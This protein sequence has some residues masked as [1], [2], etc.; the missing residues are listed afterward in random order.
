VVTAV[1]VVADEVADLRFKVSRQ[2]LVLQNVNG[3][4]KERWLG[5]SAHGVRWNFCLRSA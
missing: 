2:I 5:K 3:G 4:A 1:I